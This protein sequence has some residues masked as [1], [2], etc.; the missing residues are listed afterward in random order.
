LGEES[1]EFL[2]GKMPV[3]NDAV[4]VVLGRLDGC[5]PKSTVVRSERRIEMKGDS[6]LH[7]IIVEHL[8]GV[9]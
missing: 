4:E 8:K 3:F 1:P 7:C 9:A 2:M 6:I 5:F